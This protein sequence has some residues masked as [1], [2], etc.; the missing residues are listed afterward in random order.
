M[1]GSN[2]P[3]KSAPGVAARKVALDALVR[4]DSGGAYANL[5]LPKLLADS[6]LEQ[7]DRGLVSELVY[8]TTRMQRACDHLINP[9]VMDDLDPH[10]RNALRLGAYQIHFMKVPAHAAVSATVG[11]SRGRGRT[12]VNAILRRVAGLTP[13]W[14]SDAV[15]L[16]YPDWIVTRLVADI[17]PED[18]IRALESMNEP[19]EAVQRDDGYTQD[20]ASQEV[21]AVLNPQP[22]E[23]ILDLCSAPGGKATGMASSG[24]QVVAGDRLLNRARL[25]AK[26][27]KR[28]DQQ[29][30]V[31][32]ADGTAPPFRPGVADAV[33]VDAPCSGLGSLRRRADARWRIDAEAPERLAQIQMN[34]VLAGL[35]LVKPGGRLVYSVCTL[36]EAETSGVVDRVMAQRPDVGTDRDPLRRLPNTSDGMTTFVLRRS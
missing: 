2:K 6:G 27:V 33:L 18:A 23:L 8:G 34:L 22:G 19:A 11:A 5:V 12:V 25:V 28:L 9:F 31:V 30:P 16:S 24:A 1:S 7:R 4:I 26:N 15:R 17:G 13:V 21:V 29:L 20:P 14:P 36:T 32:V 3:R 35:Q 10:V